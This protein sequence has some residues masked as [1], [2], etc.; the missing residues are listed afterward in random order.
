MDQLAAVAQALGF[1][2]EHARSRGLVSGDVTE[3]ELKEFVE[4]YTRRGAAIEAAIDG[5][6]RK[7]NA[8]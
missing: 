2:L 4:R 1:I 5:A 3:T 8:N 6:E 7:A